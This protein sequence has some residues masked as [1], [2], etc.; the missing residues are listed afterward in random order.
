MDIKLFIE[1]S[2]EYL[3]SA[4]NSVIVDVLDRSEYGIIRQPY[5]LRGR[6]CQIYFP[7]KVSSYKPN[8]EREEVVNYISY[9]IRPMDGVKEK[10]LEEVDKMNKG[11]TYDENV[12]GSYYLPFTPGD[13]NFKKLAESLE[14]MLTR[15]IFPDRGMEFLF[16]LVTVSK[17]FDIV[18]VFLELNSVNKLA[19]RYP[20]DL[21]FNP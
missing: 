8:R 1:K 11:Q 15:D 5:I 6:Q 3:S 7:R 17:D 19:S 4:V 16:H 9:V 10:F 12:I 20:D 13:L 21:I 18:L 14:K 2:Q